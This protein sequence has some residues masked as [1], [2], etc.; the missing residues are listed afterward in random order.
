MKYKQLTKPVLKTLV[1]AIGVGFIAMGYVTQAEASAAAVF[2]PLNSHVSDSVSNNGDGTWTYNFTVHNDVTTPAFY[3]GGIIVDWELPYF[4]DMQISNIKSPAS[5]GQGIPEF[6]SYEIAT[7]GVPNQDTGWA[8]VAKWQTEGDPWKAI[9]D[10][11]YGTAEANPFNHHTKVLHWY[12]SYDDGC[13]GC[14]VGIYPNNQLSGFSFDAAYGEGQAPYQASWALGQV[15]T[16]DPAFPN[17]PN[18]SLPNSPSISAVP[19][20][21]AAVLMLSGLMGIAS[22]SRKK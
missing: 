3:G 5:S 2:R 22:F 9:F 14:E 12:I 15:I 1:S 6:W 21:G 16:G 4:D 20:P 17:S 11:E 19:V 13:N 8:G 7:I 10:A 18:L